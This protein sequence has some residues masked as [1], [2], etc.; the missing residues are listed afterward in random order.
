MVAVV[1]QY[2]YHRHDTRLPTLA[3]LLLKRIAALFPMSVLACLGN[4][5]E[6]IRDI[7]LSRLQAHTEVRATVASWSEC[8]VLIDLQVTAVYCVFF[9]QDVRLKVGIL[10]FMTV[11]VAT[12]P[13][14]LEIFLNLQ[15]IKLKVF[16]VIEALY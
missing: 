9:L 2:L 13:G 5:A 12:Q 11:C 7:F 16:N 8:L 1:A 14:L 10:E 4:N 3:T 6:P 15:Q